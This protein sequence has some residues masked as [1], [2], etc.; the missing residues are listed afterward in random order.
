MQDYGSDGCCAQIQNQKRRFRVKHS[1]PSPKQRGAILMP[2]IRTVTT[3]KY[4][5]D[6][7]AASIRLYEKK[8]E[9]QVKRIAA[10]RIGERPCMSCVDRT[11]PKG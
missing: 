11:M 9:Q 5:R 1:D 6:E 10:R 4:K 2:E 8:L 3:L 7:I